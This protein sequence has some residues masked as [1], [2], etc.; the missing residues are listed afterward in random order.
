MQTRWS[1]RFYT[2]KWV[3]LVKVFFVTLATWENTE[4]TPKK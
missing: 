2:H 1:E 3:K 4:T